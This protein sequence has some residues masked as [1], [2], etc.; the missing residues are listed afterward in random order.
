MGPGSGPASHA[1]WEVVNEGLSDPIKSVIGPQSCKYRLQAYPCYEC[2]IWSGLS[3]RWI[4]ETNGDVVLLWLTKTWTNFLSQGSSPS[5]QS[6]RSRG[7]C[8][9]KLSVTMTQASQAHLLQRWTCQLLNWRSRGSR[10]P[11]LVA[12]GTLDATLMAV[13]SHF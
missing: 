3:E 13:M 2:V 4:I 1:S 6:P 11:I 7:R 8:G 12:G 10:E 9:T 5:L